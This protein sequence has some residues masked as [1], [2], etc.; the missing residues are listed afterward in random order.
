MLRHSTE[1]SLAPGLG[2]LPFFGF[3]ICS[4]MVGIPPPQRASSTDW[5]TQ[6]RS[7][8]QKVAEGGLE[9]RSLR[10]AH[11]APLAF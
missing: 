5:V 6:P 4:N 8:G 7:H 1:T 9:P 3:S 10:L 2:Q 11:P